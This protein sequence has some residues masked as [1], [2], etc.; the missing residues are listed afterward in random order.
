M[1]C[2][3]IALLISLVGHASNAASSICDCSG[4]LASIP[5]C[6]TDGFEYHNIC[7]LKEA[8]KTDPGL[9]RRCAGPCSGTHCNYVPK[10]CNTRSLEASKSFTADDFHGI[11][12]PQE[13]VELLGIEHAGY[14]EEH[15]KR[16]FNSAM[17][18]PSNISGSG[19]GNPS[20]SGTGQGSQPAGINAFSA[21]GSASNLVAGD[22]FQTWQGKSYPS[23]FT[24]V[25]LT[26]KTEVTMKE[27][28][29]KIR[30]S[31]AK[32]KLGV[33]CLGA[34]KECSATPGCPTAVVH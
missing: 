21:S 34:C 1:Y 13:L 26:D 24:K 15:L 29:C 25:C 5:V 8:Q 28:I 31:P 3:G 27:A 12:S 33:R 17:Q 2:F 16:C 18:R 9:G 22:A 7:S 10:F 14:G 23:P 20:A 4:K 6:A 19:S 11:S 30:S 32:S